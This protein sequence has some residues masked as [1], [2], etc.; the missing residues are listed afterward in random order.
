M[1]I[2]LKYYS[3]VTGSGLVSQGEAEPWTGYEAEGRPAA[4]LESN[5]SVLP[6]LLINLILLLKI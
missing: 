2:L 5:H 1:N 4:E 6:R 3:D